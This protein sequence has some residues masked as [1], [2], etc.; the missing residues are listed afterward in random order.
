MTSET[1]PEPRVAHKQ[2]KPCNAFQ[3]QVKAYLLHNGSPS[4]IDG[5]G[6]QTDGKCSL[7]DRQQPRVTDTPKP[8]LQPYVV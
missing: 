3:H 6:N 1:E 4:S 5:Q 7:I 8:C 2:P